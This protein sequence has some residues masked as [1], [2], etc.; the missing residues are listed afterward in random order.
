MSVAL[1]KMDG[2]S[3]VTVTLKD[4]LAKLTLKPGNK[5][6]LS[7]IRRVVERSG[8]TPQRASIVAEAEEIRSASGQSQIKVSH[9]NETFP[10]AQATTEQVRAALEKHGGKRIVVEGVVPAAKD[11]PA[12][13]MAVT[14]VKPT[15][16]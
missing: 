3:A 16:K 10:L 11:N 7:E 9:S 14:A 8:F 15:G 5:V 4:G 2:V 6:T 12:G 1:Q 13:A